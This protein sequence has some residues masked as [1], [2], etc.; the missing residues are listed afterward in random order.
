[1]ICPVSSKIQ[2]FISEW[3]M[4][5]RLTEFTD[6]Y[7]REAACTQDLRIIIQNV[8]V[9]ATTWKMGNAIQNTLNI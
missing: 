9:G 2:I 6:Y 5:N 4:E 8:L 1:M 7:E 3:K